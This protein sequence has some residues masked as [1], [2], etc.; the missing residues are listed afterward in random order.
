MAEINPKLFDDASSVDGTE[1][2]P[3]YK[4]GWKKTTL[5]VITKASVEAVLTGELTSHTHA[6]SETVI[7]KTAVEAVLTGVITTHTHKTILTDIDTGIQYLLGVT[8]DTDS[9]LPTLT[10]TELVSDVITPPDSSDSVI[11]DDGSTV[12]FD[13]GSTVE[14]L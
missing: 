1:L 12:T 5:P 7:T 13:D 14:F 9:Q 3:I 11:L 2:V 4:N 10:F 6:Q 8:I